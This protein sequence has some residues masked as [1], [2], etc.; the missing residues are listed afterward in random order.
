MKITREI[1]FSPIGQNLDLR[2][3]MTDR[4]TGGVRTHKPTL[5]ELLDKATAGSFG[6]ETHNLEDYDAIFAL[7][8]LELL[9]WHC[10]YT[11]EIAE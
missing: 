11:F 8:V 5:R 1:N 9:D 7:T 2:L 6:F 3:E 10:D 4:T